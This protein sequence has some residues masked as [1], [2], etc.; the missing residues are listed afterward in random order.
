MRNHKL[1]VILAALGLAVGAGSATAAG[2]LTG[3]K[4][5]MSG[6]GWGGGAGT[7]VCKYCHAPHQAQTLAGAPL[8]N[9]ATTSQSYTLYSSITFNAKVGAIAQPGAASKMCLSCHD[10]TVASDAYFNSGA[11][12]TL[13]GLGTMTATNTV[14]GTVNGIP[15]NLGADHPIGFAYTAALAAPAANNLV[16]PFSTNSVDAAGT[17]PLY[18]SVM[19]CSTCHTSHDNSNTK[20]LRASMNQSG[21]CRTCH[22]E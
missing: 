10:G 20:F 8:W 1:V 21:L 14:G 11:D 12:N 22:K 5:D 6:N 19:E 17:L 13:S 16:S 2:M 7:E 4:H 18:G 9:H 3:T 15:H